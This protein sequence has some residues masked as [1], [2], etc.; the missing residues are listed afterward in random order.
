MDSQNGGRFGNNRDRAQPRFRLIAPLLDDTL[1]RTTFRKRRQE[2]AVKAGL[3]QTT[4]TRYLEPCKA[5]GINGNRL[6]R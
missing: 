6:P 2:I 3:S 5:E 4:V 1:N